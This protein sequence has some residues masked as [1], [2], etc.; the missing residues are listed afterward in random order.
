MRTSAR[1]RVETATLFPN[2][3]L[4][5]NPEDRVSFMLGAISLTALHTTLPYRFPSWLCECLIN[6]A[7]V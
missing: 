1:S 4:D 2:G 5:E 7:P 3:P 6:A